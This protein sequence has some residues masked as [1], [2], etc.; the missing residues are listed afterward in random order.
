[1][2]LLTT[3]LTRGAPP[4]GGTPPA[5]SLWFDLLDQQARA[6]RAWQALFADYDAVI[7]PAFGTTAYRHDDTPVTERRLAVDGEDTRYG[8]QLAFAALAS[9]P[10]LPAT[11]VPVGADADGLPIGVQVIADLWQDHKAI[12]VARA[13]HRWPGR[14]SSLEPG[15]NR[16]G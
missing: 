5:L 14:E 7:A 10:M 9:F 8:L 13:A 1:M 15:S 4:D 12:D 3:A 6:V 2:Q 11:A 16:T